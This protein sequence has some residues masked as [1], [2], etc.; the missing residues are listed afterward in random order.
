MRKIT[1]RISVT[2]QCNQRCA[3][4]R[5]ANRP[6]SAK[7]TR[8]VGLD[9]AGDF[10]LLVSKIRPVGKV[11]ITGG[12]PLLRR[13]VP[14]L[15]GRLVSHGIRD[16]SIT[17]NGRLLA[18]QADALWQAG[19][20]RI[21]IS[22]DSINPETYR[23]ITGSREL[24]GILAGI[25][26]IDRLG[27]RP[28]KINC[29]VLRSHN[30]PELPGLLRY[31]H[32]RGWQVRFLEL[33]PMGIAPSFFQQEF[34]STAE[35]RS[36][37]LSKGFTLQ[38]ACPQGEEIASRY[39]VSGP[40]GLK[41]EIGFISSQTGMFCRGCSRLRLTA[42]GKLVPCLRKNFEMDICPLLEKKSPGRERRLDKI[43][44]WAFGC[45]SS[46]LTAR[47]R[48]QMVEIGG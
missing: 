35:V 1:L 24:K 5:P 8:L 41:G 26:R 33:M 18:E 22:L 12:E 19:L 27:A 14:G 4:C 17:T 40:G 42:S 29:V 21:N 11:K 28:I 9:K 32:G 25:H 46:L 7:A 38:N 31:C 10:V 37:L 39:M 34:V 13:G 47:V 6:F 2:D 15:I 23:A 43:L 16:V 3:Y 30:L 45:K 20:R 36:I 44:D 48:K